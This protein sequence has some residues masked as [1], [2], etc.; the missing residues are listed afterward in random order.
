MWEIWD[1]ERR[2]EEKESQGGRER[3][4]V[5]RGER[6]TERERWETEETTTGKVRNI[7]TQKSM[8]KW[9]TL[10]KKWITEDCF[11][12]Y[13]NITT[14]LNRKLFTKVIKRPSEEAWVLVRQRI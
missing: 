2:K 4:R 8:I 7:H 6:E 14:I 1:K 5:R 13:P 3:E 11:T 10:F 9:V 12:K